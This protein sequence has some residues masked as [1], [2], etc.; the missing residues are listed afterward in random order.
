MTSSKSIFLKD[1]DL[2]K[3]WISIIHDDRFNKIKTFTR[4][5]LMEARPS[6]E[7]LIGCELALSTLEDLIESDSTPFGIIDAKAG[8]D[9]NLNHERKLDSEPE[10][11]ED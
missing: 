1:S 4:A 8:L 7:Q 5:S 10:S 9:H 3:W 6:G 11:K 2:L